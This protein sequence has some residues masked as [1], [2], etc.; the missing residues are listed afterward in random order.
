VRHREE[1]PMSLRQH[2][3]FPNLM[4]GALW[5]LARLELESRP[6]EWTARPRHQRICARVLVH[7]SRGVQL[8]IEPGGQHIEPSGK[9]CIGA[10]RTNPTNHR[11]LPTWISACILANS[12]LVWQADKNASASASVI[13]QERVAFSQRARG[14][15][16][17]LT[18]TN[19]GFQLNFTATMCRTLAESAST[20]ESSMFAPVGISSC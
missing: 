17:R 7:S 9:I 16:V 4:A 3:W 5:I 12:S 11:T 19:C 14:H 2:Q 6:G 15:D 8:L 13:V 18:S 10:P 1:P 20:C